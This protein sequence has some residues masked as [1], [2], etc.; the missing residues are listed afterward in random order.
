MYSSTQP[1]SLCFNFA[2]VWFNDTVKLLYLW[3][4]S[5]YSFFLELFSLDNLSISA[6]KVSGSSLLFPPFNLH[7]IL[8]TFRFSSPSMLKI[9]AISQYS[10]DIWSNMGETDPSIV[11]RRV[12]VCHHA[13]LEGLSFVCRCSHQLLKKVY[14]YIVWLCQHDLEVTLNNRLWTFGNTCLTYYM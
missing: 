13:E 1:I 11:Y 5:S 8:S 4:K 2:T 14:K 7:R 6:F 12:D 9:Q 3:V 10:S